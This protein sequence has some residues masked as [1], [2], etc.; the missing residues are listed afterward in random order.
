[1][2]KPIMEF[3]KGDRQVHYFQLPIEAWAPGGT[4]WLTVKPEIDNDATDTAAV[5]NKSFDDTKL[6]LSGHEMYDL[7]WA[8]YELEFLPTDISNVTFEA[9]ERSRSY[10]GEFVHIDA[11][12][13]PNTFPG[14]DEFIDVKIYADVKRGNS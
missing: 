14:N 13:N 5:I 9:G 10:L 4:L 11:A 1:M 3:K 2:A 6:V 8:T 12:N 7:A